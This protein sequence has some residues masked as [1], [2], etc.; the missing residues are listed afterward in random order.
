MSRK[1]VVDGV[2]HVRISESNPNAEQIARGIIE[3]YWGEIPAANDWE[4]EANTL[5]VSID[6]DADSGPSVMEVV[7]R[8]LARTKSN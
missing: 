3:E 2:E 6:E 4:H 8:I 7:G 1:A 5:F